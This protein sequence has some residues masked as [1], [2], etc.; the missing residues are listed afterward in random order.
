MFDPKTSPF[1][2]IDVETTGLLPAEDR[3]VEVGAIRLVGG[4]EE[5]RF[6]SSADTPA[7]IRIV[8]E[9]PVQIS[10]EV[11]GKVGVHPFTQTIVVAHGQKRIEFNLKLDWIG[12]PGVGNTYGQNARWRQ[13]E[14]QRAFYDDRDKL[15][16][17]FPANLKGQKISKNA[18]FDVTESRLTNTF[19]STWDG[20]KN[21]VLLNW[22][23][24]AEA[25]G[26]HGLA[27][28]ADHTT[29]YIHGADHP[30][31]LV[32]QYSGIGLWGRRYDI[33]GATS[34]RY[35]LIPHA[36]RWD[37]G[38]IPTESARWNEPL[39]AVLASCPASPDQCRKS[40]MDVT[41]TGW[42]VTAMMMEGKNLLVRLFN[43]EGDESPKQ[44]QFDANANKVELV[45][46]NGE[47]RSRLDTI[48]NQ[49][50]KTAVKISIPRFS[51]RTLR[52]TGTASPP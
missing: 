5:G 4:Q 36:G 41:G 15:L 16:A 33:N 44:V 29:S 46:L 28:L 20:I 18:P 26:D 37:K 30:P 23:D 22:M 8:E 39:V 12:N 43:A 11:N 50:G 17:L 19:F 32:L 47:V 24:V 40:L 14:N 52:L 42:E 35:A 48:S 51:I 7:T 38:S 13:E 34:V 3:V 2:V 49:S 27:L 1:V 45:E 10:L 31:G 6:H 21:N 25:A 9:G